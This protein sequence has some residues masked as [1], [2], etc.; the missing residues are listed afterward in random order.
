MSWL[1]LKLQANDTNADAI[2]DAL[3]DLGALSASIEDAH[4][5]T[6]QEQA[7]F[8]EPGDPPPG[9]WHQ[10]IVTAMMDEHADVLQL[11]QQL[12][13]AT[14]L[15]AFS[16]TTEII[17][18]QD[19]VR[20][21]QAQFDP[22]RI[23]DGLWIVPTWHTAPN[24]EAI[25]IVLDPGLAFGTGSH[26]TTHL[27]LAW[28]TTQTDMNSVL[29]YGCGSGILAIAAKKLGANTV[30]GVDIDPQALLATT[31]NAK[32]NKLPEDAMPVFLPKDTPSF[33][34]DIMLANI[35]AGPLAELA[36]ALNAMT[37]VG[38]KIC[39]SGILAIQAEA[40]KAAYAQ[41]FEFDPLATQEEW[42]RI[43][44]TKVRE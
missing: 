11:L 13:Q 20:A 5:E 41:W 18:E 38:G 8:G 31:E 29:D 12:K 27:C 44:G 1:L 42:V 17:A 15:P 40:V 6:Q 19:W 26:P 33:M 2:S 23:T 30:T 3:M 24:Q 35:L 36:P 28:L 39:L 14:G 37:K 21:T 43:T 25:N 9:I 32:R 34:A 16:Y 4:A 7:I 22:I 10:N